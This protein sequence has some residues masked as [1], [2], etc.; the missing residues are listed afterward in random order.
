MR[1]LKAEGAKIFGDDR[2]M[3]LAPIMLQAHDADAALLGEI[4]RF[5]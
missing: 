5:R 1:W 2:A 4:G 3:A